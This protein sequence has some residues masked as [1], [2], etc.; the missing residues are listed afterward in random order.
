MAISTTRFHEGFNIGSYTPS[1]H[2]PLL[3]QACQGPDNALCPMYPP[4]P[5]T[6]RQAIT[7]FA[8]AELLLLPACLASI[9]LVSNPHQFFSS[10]SSFDLNVSPDSWEQRSNCD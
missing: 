3:S 4:T 6:A 9:A 7:S 1:S 5:V 2:R 10:S 8:E